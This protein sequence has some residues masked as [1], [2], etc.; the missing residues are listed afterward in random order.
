MLLTFTSVFM[1][2]THYHYASNNSLSNSCLK[3]LLLKIQVVKKTFV[4]SL[5]EVV[6]NLRCDPKFVNKILMKKSL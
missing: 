2:K 6:Q 1:F 5:C 4:L 3:M